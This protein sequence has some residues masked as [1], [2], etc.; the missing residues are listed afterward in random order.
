MFQSNIELRGI[1]NDGKWRD[2]VLN[3]YSFFIFDYLMVENGLIIQSRVQSWLISRR[4]IFLLL[5]RLENLLGIIRFIL[6]VVPWVSIQLVS[7]RFSPSWIIFRGNNSDELRW[8]IW[9]SLCCI[10]RCRHLVWKHDQ[11]WNLRLREVRNRP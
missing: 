7:I 8:F 5:L 10:G 3:F 11:S 9:V 1:T 2:L 6:L 4:C